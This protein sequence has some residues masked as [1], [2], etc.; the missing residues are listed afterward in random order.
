MPRIR[1]E[2]TPSKLFAVMV[3]NMSSPLSSYGKYENREINM[4]FET[5]HI[6]LFAVCPPSKGAILHLERPMTIDLIEYK[7]S[8]IVF[9]VTPA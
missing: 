2:E 6:P 1:H 3:R 8:K 5:K 9:W 4:C 7:D